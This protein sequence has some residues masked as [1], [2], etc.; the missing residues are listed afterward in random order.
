MFLKLIEEALQQGKTAL[1]LVPEISLT[2][3]MIRRLKMKFGKRVAVQH[4]ALNNT[5]R[6]LQWQ[7]I[8]K[9]GAD[10]VVGTRSAI[11]APLQNLGLIIMDEEQE[12]T[13]HSESSPRYS[14]HDVARMRAAD[15]RAL[16]V[17][18]SAT[19]SVERFWGA[20][21]GRMQMV[22]LTQRYS[23]RPLPSVELVDMRAELAAGNAGEISQPLADQ[24]KATLQQGKQAILLLN[25]RGYRTV[26]QCS[27]CGQSLKCPSCSVPMVYHKAQHMLA[28]W[29]NFLF[30]ML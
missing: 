28:F 22:R 1:V 6:L 21:Q 20:Q 9:G 23:G 18:A 3:Q 30:L 25:R 7:M 11:F 14:A 15:N 13:Y 26:A 17:L 5:E 19:P 29:L 24:L 4:S 27:D 16:L 2:P 12:H 8:Q 10:I